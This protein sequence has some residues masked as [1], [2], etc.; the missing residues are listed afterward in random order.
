MPERTVEDRLREEYFTLL[1]DAR[2]VVEELEAVAR[3]CLLPVFGRLDKYERIAV[4]SR[5][6][7][8]ESAVD[9]LR[10]RQ[11]SATFDPGRAESYTLTA[12]NDLAGVRVLAF[13]RSRLIEA[14]HDLRE[15][16]LNV[17]IR[18]DSRR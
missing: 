1:P 17:D 4:T 2:R 9:A 5:I 14:D 10:R 12:L 8:C 3:H 18:S 16:F 11:E 15:H 13:P 7:D 6:K